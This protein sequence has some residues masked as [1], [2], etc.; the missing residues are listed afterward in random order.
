MGLTRL[1][2][3]AVNTF[4]AVILMI[5]AIDTLPQSPL[6]LRLALQPLIVRL[7]I[8]QGP[9]LLFGPDPDRTNIRL[10][11]EILYRDGQRAEWVAPDWRQQSSWE[12]WTGHRRHE[13]VDT[14]VYQESAA[15]WEPWCRHLAR[16]LRPDL[17]EA[18]RG[19]EVRLI[20]QE[21]VVPPAENKPWRSIREPTKFDSGWVLTIEKL[22]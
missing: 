7:G 13:W 22:E 17:P 14:M 3:Y 1:R 6:G 10:R 8:A 16:T 11:A 9:W 19:A 20:Y 4:I 2:L 15:A 21:A 12:M 5:L 18:D